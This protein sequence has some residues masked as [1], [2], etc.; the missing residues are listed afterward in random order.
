M[1]AK[2]EP[3]R[4]VAIAAFWIVFSGR[5]I[6]P[7]EQ[8]TEFEPNRVVVAEFDGEVPQVSEQFRR[9][10]GRVVVGALHRQERV[11]GLAQLAVDAGEGG[12]A[13]VRAEAVRVLREAFER[14]ATLGIK[15]VAMADVFGARLSASY[16][17]L[18]NR[19][20]AQ[21]DVATLNA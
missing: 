11:L 5:S 18:K 8:I 14:F 15:L 4:T 19:F 3:G 17:H 6:A 13:A 12:D 21:V 2:V 1:R 10:L 9:W 20:A 16:G 7:P